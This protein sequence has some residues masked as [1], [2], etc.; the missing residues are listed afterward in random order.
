MLGN[1]GRSL[2]KAIFTPLA[3]LLAR[4]GVTPNQVTIIGTL[5]S[6]VIAISTLPFGH[7]WEGALLLGIV[8]FGDSVDGT[9]ARMTTGGSRFGAF[10][11][12]TLDR[13]SDGAVFASLTAWAIFSFPE[14]AAR[15]WAIAAGLA[16]IIGAG[17]VPYARA[18]AESI[19]IEAKLGIAER[20]DRLIA[21]LLG[22]LLADWGWG[23]WW[24]TAGLG[25]VALGSFITVVQ[26]IVFTAAE[27]SRRERESADPGAERERS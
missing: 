7:V 27:A 2:T 19:G 20:T 13:L 16:A 3:R 8:L 24:L 15:T 9:L 4:A 5:A 25:W 21:A 14:G 17:T 18:R 22:G 12:S 1:H 6:V 11:D 23:E 26:R 10:L